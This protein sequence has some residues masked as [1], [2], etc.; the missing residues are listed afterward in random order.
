MKKEVNCSNENMNDYK[1]ITTPN[2][3]KEN[4]HQRTNYENYDNGNINNHNEVNQ[5]LENMAQNQNA[6]GKN[7]TGE[8]PYISLTKRKK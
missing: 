7:E 4:E 6:N 5:N 2:Q 8:D 3:L 1:D